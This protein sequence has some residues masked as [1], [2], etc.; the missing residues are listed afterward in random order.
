MIASVLIPITYLTYSLLVMI[1]LYKEYS[2]PPR[3]AIGYGILSFCLLPVISYVT[4]RT[5]E[6]GLDVLKSLKPLMMNLFGDVGA[7]LRGM[8]I[9]LQKDLVGVIEEYGPKVIEGW[10]AGGRMFERKDIG[11]GGGSEATSSP[12]WQGS[13]HRED[14][15][16]ITS[17]TT[18][19]E[20]EEEDD[21]KWKELEGMDFD[22]GVFFVKPRKSES[23]L[24][25]SSFG[26][27]STRVGGP[28]NSPQ[29]Q[30]LRDEQRTPS[31]SMS[32]HSI[33]KAQVRAKNLQ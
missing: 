10:E 22:D 15:D 6:I 19:E 33:S 32:N 9:G 12:H 25:L 28:L 31:S 7:G 17:E 5:G 16:S 11:G 1:I 29:S 23:F 30:V 8:R 20:E 3:S 26:L 24:D 27:D 4:I 13:I 2:F 18:L 21:L 14:G